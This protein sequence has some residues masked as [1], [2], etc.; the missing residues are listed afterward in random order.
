VAFAVDIKQSVAPVKY[1]Q[2]RSLVPREFTRDLAARPLAEVRLKT[3]EREVRQVW[4]AGQPW[5]VYSSNGPTET[6]LVEVIPAKP[7]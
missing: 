1:D 4:Q 3:S 7:K 2:V 6:R 5:P